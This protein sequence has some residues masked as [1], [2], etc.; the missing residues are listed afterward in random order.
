[1]SYSPPA[2]P[3]PRFILISL[4]L[5]SVPSLSLS[6]GKRK[7]SGP[8]VEYG[9]WYKACKVDRWVANVNTLENM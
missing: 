3:L 4:S 9:S 8:Y 7:D 1:M 2:A 6:Q 5:F